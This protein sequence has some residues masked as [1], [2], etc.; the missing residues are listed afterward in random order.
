MKLNPL[1]VHVYIANFSKTE[2]VFFQRIT[3]GPGSSIETR[4]PKSI[5]P[6]SQNTEKRASKK[7]IGYF[8]DI[9][10]ISVWGSDQ[11]QIAN[12]G[13]LIKCYFGAIVSALV[14]SLIST[15]TI[16]KIKSIN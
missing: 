15:G 13:P 2:N 1:V 4:T 11:P 9:H 6:Y 10:G 5:K 12:F 8:T 14:T 3:A 16:S 7:K